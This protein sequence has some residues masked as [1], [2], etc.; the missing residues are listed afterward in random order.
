MFPE[1]DSLAGAAEGTAYPLTTDGLRTGGFCVGAS[2]A[3][4]ATLIGRTA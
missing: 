4:V 1:G 2:A 3:S